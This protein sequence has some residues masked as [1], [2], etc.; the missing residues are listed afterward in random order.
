M[1]NITLALNLTKS[2]IKNF[3]WIIGL[4]ISVITFGQDPGT[5]NTDFGF[6]G[7]GLYGQG[8]LNQFATG[9]IATMGE[10]EIV[11]G[12]VQETASGTNFAIYRLL[13]D[14]NFDPSFNFDGRYPANLNETDMMR[15]L[16][17]QAD[18]KIVFCGATQDPESGLDMVIGRV[19]KNGLNDDTFGNGGLIQ[20]DLSLGGGE[21]AERVYVSRDDEIIIAGTMETESDLY[22]SILKLNQNG[23]Y[24]QS[25]GNGG[26]LI[27]P[28]EF[29]YALVHDLKVSNDGSIYVAGTVGQNNQDRAIVLKINSD[30]A[31]DP[32]FA[33]DGMKDFIVGIGTE[34]HAYTIEVDQEDR[35]YIGG[36]ADRNNQTDAVLVRLQPNGLKDPTFGT[37]GIQFYDLSIGG[38]EIWTD[39]QQV[40]ADGMLALATIIVNNGR[41]SS[42]VQLKMNGEIDFNYGEGTGQLSLDATNDNEVINRFTANDGLAYTLGNVIT[43][44]NHQDFFI[45]SS[46]YDEEATTSAST[47]HIGQMGIF[48]NPSLQGQRTMMHLQEAMSGN[49]MLI[50]YN[51]LG[52]IVYQSP[53][54]L[55][56]GVLEY[57]LPTNLLPGSYHVCL[58]NGK[59]QTSQQLII[60]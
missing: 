12:G 50:I 34:I 53:V 30:G 11:F 36:V 31:L 5:F 40:S 37:N 57:P 52:Q 17:I 21:I 18:G 43:G 9:S 6:G 8:D 46:H 2:A 4:F 26:R 10:G 49:G 16:T 32:S 3:N 35:V 23:T 44:A 48:P 7:M 51:Y 58:Y 1:I 42:L 13:P 28:M 33:G 25:F 22:F 47:S 20:I 60:H 39:I 15:D 45:T 54:E 56:H 14:G 24:N 27:I 41:T 19:N 59:G 55:S 29:D 38:A